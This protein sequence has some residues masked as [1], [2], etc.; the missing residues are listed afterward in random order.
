MSD[1]ETLSMIHAGMKEDLGIKKE[2]SLPHYPSTMQLDIKTTFKDNSYDTD[3]FDSKAAG[4]FKSGDISG[5]LSIDIDFQEDELEA[6]SPQRFTTKYQ[7]AMKNDPDSEPHPSQMHGTERT[8]ALEPESDEVKRA[9][10][11]YA[12]KNVEFNDPE[13]KG[14][15]MCN[16]P[17]HHPNSMIQR[18]ARIAPATRNLETKNADKVVTNNDFAT[19]ISF[20]ERIQGQRRISF[21]GIRWTSTENQRSSIIRAS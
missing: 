2:R 15:D 5:Q 21:R 13:S 18:A 9:K 14:H 16:G 11:R 6:S 20:Q 4:E 10:A 17:A 8:A 1:N 7:Q 3:E 12:W 19:E